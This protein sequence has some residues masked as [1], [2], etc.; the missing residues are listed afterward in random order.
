MKSLFGN[1]LIASVALFCLS[2]CLKDKVGVSLADIPGTRVV[3]LAPIDD[4]IT[5]SA[6]SRVNTISIGFKDKKADDTIT[7]AVYMADAAGPLNKDVIVTLARDSDAITKYNLANST[8]FAFLPNPFFVS[9]NL[10]VTIPAGQNVGYFK[11]R[12]NDTNLSGNNYMLAY[13]II[14]APAPLSISVD[15]FYVYYKISA[16]N[17]YDGSYTM[18]GSTSGLYDYQIQTYGPISSTVDL[19]TVDDSTCIM[20]DSY[21]YS[22]NYR[23]PYGNPVNGHLFW[24]NGSNVWSWYGYFCP[25][26]HFSSN[27]SGKI[28]AVTNYF[29]QPEPVRGRYALLSPDAIQAAASSWNPNTRNV[30]ASYL[31]YQ[32]SYTGGWDG[33]K[34]WFHDVLTFVS[35]RP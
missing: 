16:R 9:E 26:L 8:S 31:M 24:E 30:E 11:L 10:Q 5:A 14:S 4:G 34:T 19:V 28:V 12:I 3:E 29:G 13:K 23:D 7:I 32:S 21:L 25:V 20:R 2:S 17:R 6:S 1:M 18:S 22:T 35:E 15:R 27:G 33:C